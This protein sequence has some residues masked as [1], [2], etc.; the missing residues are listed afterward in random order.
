MKAW[1]RYIPVAEAEGVLKRLYGRVA[2]A[3]G[4]VDNILKVHSLRPH[5]LEGHLALYK[6]VLHHSANTLPPWLL[7]AAGAWV[8][9]LNGCR[10]C[11]RHHLAGMAR[12]LA[13][14]ARSAAIAAAIEARTPEQAFEGP[15]LAVMRYAQA[16]TE[17]PGQMKAAH[18]D[19]LRSAGFEDGEILELNQVVAYFAYANRTVNG[20]GVTLEGDVLGLSPSNTADP[21]D[22]SHQ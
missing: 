10:Y 16:L 21:D 20:L 15:E 1:I 22:F 14:P 19:A 11:Y 3:D 17:T 6:R 2:S 13:D 7:E 4:Y 5:S 8:S 18:V 9:F 12:R